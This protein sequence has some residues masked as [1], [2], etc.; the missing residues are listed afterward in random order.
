VHKFTL[1]NGVEGSETVWYPLLKTYEL[2]EVR[3]VSEFI[4][5][6]FKHRYAHITQVGVAMVEL[7][8]VVLIKGLKWKAIEIEIFQKAEKTYSEITVVRYEK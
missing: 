1:D 6:G 2:C 8:G 5:H 7:G 4:K 3:A